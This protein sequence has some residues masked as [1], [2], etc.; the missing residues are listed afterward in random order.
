MNR[1]LL[2]ILGLSICTLAFGQKKDVVS[3]KDYKKQAEELILFRQY[4]K[5]AAAYEKSYALK[6]QRGDLLNLAAENYMLERDFVNAARVYE[7]IADDPKYKEAKLN[8][9]Y[10]LKQSN[11]Y[12]L[13]MIAFASYLDMIAGKDA[14]KEAKINKEIMGCQFALEQAE[15]FVVKPY[16][17]NIDAL[18]ANINSDKSEFA[19][20]H[21]S[22]T[23]LYYSSLEDGNAKIKVSDFRDGDWATG[24]DIKGFGSIKN[25]HFC[26]AVVTPNAEEMYFTIC[27]EDQV[28]GGLSSRCDIYVS[29]NK[30]KAWGQPKKLNENVNFDGATNTQ[31]FVVSMGGQ[32]HIY[33]ASNRPDGQGGMDLWFATRSTTEKDAAF[34]EPI[35][36]GPNVNTAENEITPFYDVQDGVLYFS[37]DGHLTMGGFDILKAVGSGFNWSPAE[38]IGLPINSGADEKYY[39]IAAN[40]TEGYFVSNRLFEGQKI[41]T[42]HED[43]F[44]FNVLPPHYFVEGAINNN[45]DLSLVKDAQIFLYELKAK[46]QD[47]RLLSTKPSNGGYYNFRLL[48]NRN[49]QLS[50][51]AD[52]FSPN[53]EYVSTND[54][55]MYVQ[56]R[57]I[58]LFPSDME[59]AVASS[60]EGLSETLLEQPTLEN[61]AIQENEIAIVTE[62]E[63]IDQFFEEQ[64][65]EQ[66][67]SVV[68]GATKEQ[69]MKLEAQEVLVIG[70]TEAPLEKPS[71]PS[72]AKVLGNVIEE[73]VVI[74]ATEGMEKPTAK[75]DALKEESSLD[76]EI[77]PISQ[78]VKVAE[79]EANSPTEKSD[80]SYVSS[81]ETFISNTVISEAEDTYATT[82]NTSNIVDNNTSFNAKGT[83]NASSETN[84]ITYSAPVETY[85]P[86]EVS[87]PAIIYDA[88]AS[89]LIMGTSYK[90]QLIAVEYHNPE[91]RRYDGIKN[92]GLDL[93]TEYITG[94]GWTRVLLGGFRTEAEARAMVENAQTNGFKRAFVVKY[95]DGQRGERVR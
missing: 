4:A 6:P 76:A 84:T 46:T 36:L 43:I 55:N 31:P 61:V 53:L 22:D 26:N 72:L 8:Y 64:K 42:T 68:F 10:S 12:E 11:Q 85:V 41:S 60:D 7:G 92:L 35:N 67:E 52:G 2:L 49:Y 13:A 44:T 47:R 58:K 69:P 32:Q 17:I 57:N 5:A 91:N 51:E 14:T 75:A 15:G 45:Q 88:P 33:F 38:N 28:W 78:E 48:P 66:K 3:W 79:V 24:V 80:D 74:G 94:K 73:G 65:T 71:A 1:V 59:D 77:E 18:N 81:P 86:A 29:I 93:E 89:N 95:L 30:G 34:G 63:K 37:S 70:A 23:Q 40:N 50:V 83:V 27:N 21:F 25:K 19:P 54:E 62:D 9:A 39:T 16:D 90:V 56:E 87:K 82:T 20:F